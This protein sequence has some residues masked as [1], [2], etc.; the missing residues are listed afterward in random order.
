MSDDYTQAEIV[1]SLKR[2]EDGQ[3]NL[4]VIVSGLSTQYVPRTEHELVKSAQAADIT[5]VKTD[6]KVEI[7]AVKSDLSTDIA[8]IKAEAT[9]RTAPW[10]SVL[11]ALTGVAGVIVALLAIYSH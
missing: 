9:R 5:A 6:L 10:W 7:A 8:E 1:R 2:I 3:A 11:A 4:V